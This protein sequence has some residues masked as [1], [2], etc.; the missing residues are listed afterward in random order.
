MS[1]D[2]TAP[3]R[4]PAVPRQRSG[5]PLVESAPTSQPLH[6]SSVRPGGCLNAH[7]HGTRNSCPAARARAR[8]VAEVKTTP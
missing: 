1:G 7:R 2:A 8:G 6:A 5:H 3:D 4:A